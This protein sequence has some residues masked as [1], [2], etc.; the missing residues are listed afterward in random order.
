[1]L[2]ADAELTSDQ[3]W[4]LEG[5]VQVGNN[6]S[7]AVLSVQ[8]GTD[9][10]GDSDGETDHLLVWP[11]SALQANGTSADPVRFMSDDDDVD[12]RAEWGGVFLRGFNGLPTLT[13]EQGANRLDYVVVA[14][15]GAQVL[16]LIHI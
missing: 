5:R 4:F 15:A 16:S 11:G 12:G 14:E 7:Q 9:V 8:A 13:G 2:T 1:M 3:T 10:F 6:D